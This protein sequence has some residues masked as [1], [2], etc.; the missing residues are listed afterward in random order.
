VKVLTLAQSVCPLPMRKHRLHLMGSFPPT[1]LYNHGEVAR[2]PTSAVDEA[3]GCLPAIH[4]RSHS[5]SFI[6]FAVEVKIIH[7]LSVN[8]PS[9]LIHGNLTDKVFI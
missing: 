8:G 2:K 1:C 4:R 3:S 5:L 6:V 7:P 9:T